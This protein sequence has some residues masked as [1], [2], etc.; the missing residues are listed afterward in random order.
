MLQDCLLRGR[1]ISE[2][3]DLWG[4][5]EA[6]GTPGARARIAA[7]SK[8]KPTAGAASRWALLPLDCACTTLTGRWHW[9]EQQSFSMQMTPVTP[10][11][12]DAC[13]TLAEGGKRMTLVG[14]CLLRAMKT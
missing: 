4:T 14:P 11:H 10:A 7:G 6:P 1:P 12:F 8:G 9:G 2:A 13:A 3:L 5:C